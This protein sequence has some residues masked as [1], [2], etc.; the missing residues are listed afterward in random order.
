[1]DDGWMEGGTLRFDDSGVGDC[2]DDNENGL[3][4]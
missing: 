4:R 2:V 1:M 3:S